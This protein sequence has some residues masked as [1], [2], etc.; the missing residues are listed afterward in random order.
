[1]Q[2]VSSGDMYIK[3]QTLFSEE[4]KE[5]IWKCLLEFLPNMLSIKWLE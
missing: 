4:K 1:M 2:I 5:N 3:W